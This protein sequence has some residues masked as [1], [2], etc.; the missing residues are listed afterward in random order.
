M[1][2]A[3]KKMWLGEAKQLPRGH[4]ASK[5]QKWD[6]LSG[7]FESNASTWTPDYHFQCTFLGQD[8]GG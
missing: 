8:P 7:L 1:I 6:V 3:S 4:T 2:M 5:W